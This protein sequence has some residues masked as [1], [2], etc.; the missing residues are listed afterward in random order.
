M[1]ESLFHRSRFPGKRDSRRPCSG[2]TGGAPGLSGKS[3]PNVF[4]PADLLRRTGKEARAAAGSRRDLR[5]PSPVRDLPGVVGALKRPPPQPR[6]VVGEL[7]WRRAPACPGRGWG[8]RGARRRA[9]GYAAPARPYTRV[10]P[11]GSGLPRI[12]GGAGA[13]RSGDGPR[14]GG[15]R[16]GG[17]PLSSSPRTR[18]GKS[19][20]PGSRRGH[21]AKVW[22]QGLRAQPPGV[23]F[24]E[25]PQGTRAPGEGAFRPAGYGPLP[26]AP[27]GGSAV[28]AGRRERK[29]PLS[30]PGQVGLIEGF[31]LRKVPAERIPQGPEMQNGGLRKDA[32]YDRHLAG[33]GAA[34]SPGALHRGRHRA[35][36]LEL[37][38]C[39]VGA[40]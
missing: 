27:P 21:A 38:V 18:G 17:N 8:R 14:S 10:P 23:L 33:S 12:A 39:G 9:G 29:G 37:P 2:G 7:P 30:T 3:F 13:G 5:A 22:P 16:A 31:L 32:R 36:G 26:A 25:V 28:G 24:R 4:G 35:L 6:R 20:G 19:P 11:L 34:G 40:P 15:P 1:E